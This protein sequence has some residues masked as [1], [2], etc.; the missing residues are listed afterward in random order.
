MFKNME[1]NFVED[2]FVLTPQNILKNFTLVMELGECM[3]EKIRSDIDYQVEDL[4]NPAMVWV[5]IEHKEPQKL[6]IE[7]TDIA[8]GE[9][10]YFRCNCGTRS[11]KLYLLPD[12]KEFRCRKCHNLKYRLSS[13]N[14]NSIAGMSI[15]KLDRLHKLANERSSMSRI[16]YKG[17]YTKRFKRFLKICDKAGLESIVK[18]ANDLKILI[19]GQRF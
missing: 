11:A 16:F 8:F 19:Q 13:F 12:G 5:S 10:A 15:Y 7:W 17:D 4:G 6:T 14:K 9:R 18:G 2:C 3:Y 1:N